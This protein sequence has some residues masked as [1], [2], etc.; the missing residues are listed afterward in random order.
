M[1][2]RMV[3][4]AMVFIFLC[5]TDFSKAAEQ[6][7]PARPIEIL[8][9]YAPGGGADLATRM[10]AET[11]KKFI[12]GDIVVINKPGGGGRVAMSL[13]A[14]AKPD[15]YTLGATT[16]SCINLIPHMEK[17]SYKPLDDFTFI[18]QFT[19]M[20]LVVAVKTDS[21]L[22][23]FKDLIEYARKNPNKLTISTVGVGTVNDIAFRVIAEREKVQI[24]LV[25]YNA[26]GQTMTALLG[27]H[28][29]VGSCGSSGIS[30]YIRS[31]DIR[32]LAVMN[33][34]R[35]ADYPDVP[36]LRELGYPFEF[37]SM[38]LISAPKNMDKAIVKKLIEG[39]KKG[40][41]TA[42]Y[43]KSLKEMDIYERNPLSGDGLTERIVQKNRKYGEILGNLGMATKQ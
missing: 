3:F 15:G 27:G 6:T 28:V 5:G 10:L 13:V 42:D 25:P 19:T 4:L 11:S 20:E 14:K 8:V 23:T 24:N 22:K 31:K 37:Q 9:G 30:P 43:V 18:T 33:D 32:L 38:H 34:S 21:P 39:F 2:A 36:T 35:L 17:V 29:M 26:A 7:F 16:D 1:K 41:E 12:G 40:M